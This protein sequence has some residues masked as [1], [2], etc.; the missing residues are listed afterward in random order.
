MQQDV[1]LSG[2]FHFLFGRGTSTVIF[3][4]KMNC[5]WICLNPNP[6]WSILES[7]NNF[8]KFNTWTLKLIY[9]HREYWTHFK[10]HSVLICYI[11]PHN[12]IVTTPSKDTLYFVKIPIPLYLI[13]TTFMYFR[14][15]SQWYL[16]CV[17][18]E[19]EPGIGRECLILLDLILPQ[20]LVQLC[21]KCL[22]SNLSNTWNNL[23]ASVEQVCM[24]AEIMVF[25]DVLFICSYSSLLYWSVCLTSLS[26]D[27]NT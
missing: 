23:R 25:D 8:E 7:V 27:V 17:T 6:K 1:F 9:H 2:G 20:T 14:T 21:V 22:N 19:C 4:N 11:K 15:I 24:F 13:V 18:K 12:I 26:P 10:L 16:S 5:K 3:V